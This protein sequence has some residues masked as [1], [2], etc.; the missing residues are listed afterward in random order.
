LESLDAGNYKY[1]TNNCALLREFGAP[2]AFCVKRK[3]YGDNEWYWLMDIQIRID[4]IRKDLDQSIKDNSARDAQSDTAIRQLIREREQQS[5]VRSAAMVEV[6][7]DE[8]RD[9]L[10]ALRSEVVALRAEVL[11]CRP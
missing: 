5:A 10:A 6:E 4:G 2:H 1:D 11:E 9:A 3:L 7:L 8:L